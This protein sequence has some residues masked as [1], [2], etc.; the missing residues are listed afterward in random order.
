MK[1]LNL[2]SRPTQPLRPLVDFI[3]SRLDKS[4]Q[5]ARI[6]LLDQPN[7]A[8]TSS[9][10]AE[11]RVP[12]DAA[13]PSRVT[14]YLSYDSAINFPASFQHV[15]EIKPFEIRSWEEEVLLVLAHELRHVVQFWGDEQMSA[16]VMEVDAEAFAIS[17]VKAWRI[18]QKSNSKQ[19]A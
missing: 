14:V 4:A 19:A 13:H 12:G 1:I 15:P 7:A 11:M 16:H 18:A 3:L 2:S 17:T 10:L 6:Q 8:Q 9:G 5:L